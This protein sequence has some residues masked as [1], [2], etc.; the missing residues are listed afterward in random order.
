MDLVKLVPSGTQVV[1]IP[2]MGIRIHKAIGWGLTADQF[3]E[4]IGFKLPDG[5]VDSLGEALWDKL[6]AIT[7]LT[8]PERSVR[9]IF[10]EWSGFIGQTNLLA[11]S[12]RFDD[13]KTIQAA[14]QVRSA[15][16]LYENVCDYDEPTTVHLFL[17]NAIY[18]S[19]FRYDDALDYV[20]TTHDL[21]TG[22]FADTPASFHCV[23]LKQNPYPWNLEFMDPETGEQIVDPF[24][25]EK[26]MVVPK[27]PAELRWWLTETGILKPDGWKLLRPY[28][29]RWWR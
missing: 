29:A 28:Y 18:T 2:G 14:D 7:E 10:E 24:G 8:I 12:F 16:A 15:T 25:D 6:N 26:D 21:A 23:E 13:A 3:L 9:K 1:Y 17:P 11:K 20:E 4:N 5:D 22:D 19:W 27:P